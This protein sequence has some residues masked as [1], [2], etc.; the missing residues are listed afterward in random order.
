MNVYDKAA[1][2]FIPGEGCGFVMLKRLEDARR[3]G[4]RVYAVLRGWGISS[5]EGGIMTPT[6]GGQAL[7]IRRAYTSAGYSPADLDS[8]RDMEREPM[9]AM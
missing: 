2:G 8:L 9:S 4:Y 6:S 1:A 3:D 5:M 7:A